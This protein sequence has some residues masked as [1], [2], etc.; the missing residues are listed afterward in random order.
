MYRWFADYRQRND[1]E[2]AEGGELITWMNDSASIR[3]ADTTSDCRKPGMVCKDSPKPQTDLF[4]DVW[5]AKKLDESAKELTRSGR[6]KGRANEN[7]TRIVRGST[8]VPRARS[9]RRFHLP[10][11]GYGECT[12][13]R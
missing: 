13:V 10:M 8:F 5:Q 1:A 2:R 3:T 11:G 4:K 6:P 9:A 7:W 12:H